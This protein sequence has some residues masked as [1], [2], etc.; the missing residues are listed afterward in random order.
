[1]ASRLRLER[2]GNEFSAIHLG[3]SGR[4]GAP[5]CQAGRAQRRKAC[6]LGCSLLQRPHLPPPLDNLFVWSDCISLL[7]FLYA[8]KQTSENNGQP[9]CS[10]KKGLLKERNV[11]TRLPFCLFVYLFI[12][13]DAQLRAPAEVTDGP[14][15]TRTGCL[16]SEN[17]GDVRKF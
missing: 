8:W 1:M 5:A 14:G 13:S 6:T 2:L 3:D 10:V 4:T 12:C 9:V 17:R 11:S 16:V 15:G 7:F